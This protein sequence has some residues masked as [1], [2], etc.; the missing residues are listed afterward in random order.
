MENVKT[1]HVYG[2]LYPGESHNVTRRYILTTLHKDCGGQILTP[3]SIRGYAL[4]W[5]TE[6]LKQDGTP[7]CLVCLKQ[8]LGASETYQDYC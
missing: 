5:K 1:P 4:S 6:R 7:G 8:P 2:D 3:L